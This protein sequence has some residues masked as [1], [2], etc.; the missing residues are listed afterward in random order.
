MSLN[1]I[2]DLLVHLKG[3]GEDV[4]RDGRF[5]AEDGIGDGDH[6]RVLAAETGDCDG[7]LGAEVELEVDE[8]LGEHEHVTLANHFGDEPVVG[9]GGDEADVE[10]AF[11]HRQYLR[12]PGMDVRRVEAVRCEIQSSH[13]DAEGVEAG[14]SARRS[15][16]LLSLLPSPRKDMAASYVLL[17]AALLALASSPTMARDPG[18]LQDFCVADNTSDV[19]VNGFVCKDPKLVKAEDFFFSGLDEPRDTTNKVG[20][21]VTLLNA[22]RIPGLNTLG[23][24]MARVDYAPFGLNPPHIHPRAT[25]IQTV[26]EGSL[27]VGFVTSNPD[28]RLVTKVVRKG[29]VFVFPQGLIHFQFNLGAKPA[30]AVSGLSSQNPGVITI[31]NS[32]FGSKP[33]ISDDILA[34]AF[35]PTPSSSPLSLPWLLPRPWPAIPVL[36]RTYN[37]SNVFV[38]GFVCKDPKLV[39]AEDFFFSGLDEPRDTTNKVGSNVTLLNASRIPGLNTLGISMAR[40]DYAPFGL[41]PPHIHPRATEIQTVLEGSLYVGFVTSNPDNRLVTK[42]VRKGDV[43]VFPQGL[44]HFQFNLGAKPAV[45][46]SGLSSQNPGV[47]T[48]ANSVF[49]SKPAISDDILAKAFQVDKKIIDRIQAHF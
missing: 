25:E 35:Q 18:A 27:Y 39:K 47:I 15:T 46:V 7:R 21:N 48:I 9:V 14:N 4:I 37:T 43:F 10:R 44:I 19:F 31:A 28:N 49:G 22:S 24:S 8:A 20:S 11:Q 5:G 23:I 40:V 3:L 1:P 45:A 36:S 2:Y 6:P 30:V 42:V 34:K 12:R 26:L 32:V 16:K 13:G 41:N 33:A 38:N 29:D 17:L